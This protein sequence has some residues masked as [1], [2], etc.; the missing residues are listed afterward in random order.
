MSRAG[1]SRPGFLF[2]WMF[3]KNLLS[4]FCAVA[5]A[6][7]VMTPA[8]RAAGDSASLDK[9][10]DAF[11]EA[12]TASYAPDEE[13][14]WK[15]IEYSDYGRANDVLLLQLRNRGC[16]VF[17]GHSVFIQISRGPYIHLR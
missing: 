1:D 7:S 16:L 8:M 4:V 17:F 3:M 12:A 15:F 11:V 14:T 13:V 5:V 10:R 6:M 2:L 9:V